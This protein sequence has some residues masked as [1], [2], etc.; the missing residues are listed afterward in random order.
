[1]NCVLHFEMLISTEIMQ[2]KLTLWYWLELFRLNGY[3]PSFSLSCPKWLMLIIGS[4]SSDDAKWSMVDP[5]LFTHIRHWDTRFQ[6][7][8]TPFDSHQTS[9]SR[10]GFCAF[11]SYIAVSLSDCCEAFHLCHC[12]YAY[13]ALT[14]F[15]LYFHLIQ[16]AIQ[17]LTSIDLIVALNTD[18]RTMVQMPICFQSNA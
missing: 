6:F 7:I 18:F 4:S 5:K 9:A 14:T 15:Q 10:A 2:P 11:A 13:W 8:S 1:M 16:N 12:C 17:N 3:I